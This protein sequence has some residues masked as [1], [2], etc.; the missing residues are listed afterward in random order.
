M[1][2]NVNENKDR[3]EI[4]SVKRVHI[5]IKM[6]I[7]MCKTSHL[8]AKKRNYRIFASGEGTKGQVKC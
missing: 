5:L 2:N 4:L 7:G 3:Y 6:I 1:Q 8:R